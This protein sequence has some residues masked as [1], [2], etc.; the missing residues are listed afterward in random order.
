MKKSSQHSRSPIT[1]IFRILGASLLG[2][3][4]GAFL[5]ILFI[6]IM[7]TMHR[8]E[9]AWYLLGIYEFG[10]PIMAALFGVAFGVSCLFFAK[11]NGQCGFLFQDISLPAWS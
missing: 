10:V 7:S 3:C 4:F 5:T 8:G 1:R 9:E 2:A 6:R 11:S